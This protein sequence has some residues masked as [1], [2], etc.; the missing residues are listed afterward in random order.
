MKQALVVDEAGSVGDFV[1]SALSESQ[2]DLTVVD[3]LQEAL[4]LVSIAPYQLIAIA[5]RPCDGALWYMVESIKQQSSEATLILVQAKDAD[6]DFYAR[7][8]ELG[9]VVLSAPL[10]VAAQSAIQTAILS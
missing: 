8:Q 6:A 5:A 9:A 1:G 10:G 4:A 7:A 2:Y 3:S